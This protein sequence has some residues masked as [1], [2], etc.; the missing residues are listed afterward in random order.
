M[1]KRYT[2]VLLCALI[3]AT[4]GA[5]YFFMYSASSDQSCADRAPAPLIVAFGDSLV[6]GYGATTEGGFVALLTQALGVPITNLGKNGDTTA[7]AKARL[8][9][10][11][12]ASP[13]ITLV[14]LGGNDALRRVSVEETEKNLREIVASLQ[15]AGSRVVLLGVIGGFPRDPYAPMYERLAEEFDVT[16]VSNVL[17]GIITRADLMSDGI[18]PNQAGYKKIAD[19]LLPIIEDE[20]TE[21]D[22]AP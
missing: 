21:L 2:L 13:D 10:V 5:I 14:L 3:V 8:E 6:A 4:V 22:S 11:V 9:A 18:H 19:R 20:C 16:Y 7:Q 12:A 1:E 17:S 15:K